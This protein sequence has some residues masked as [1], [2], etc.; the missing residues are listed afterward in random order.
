MP[1]SRT[2]KDE[3]I[4]VT[5][6][7]AKGILNGLEDLC[8]ESDLLSEG[9]LQ[10]LSY[11]TQRSLKRQE[12]YRVILVANG[13][14]DLKKKLLQTIKLIRMS[15]E[16]GFSFEPIGIFYGVGVS[17]DRVAFLFPGQGSQ[18]VDMGRDLASIYGKAFSAWERASSLVFDGQRIIDKVFAAEG[19]KDEELAEMERVLAGSDWTHPCIG[20]VSGS[21]LNLLEAMGLV[22]DAVTGHS[23]GD[24]TA[25]Y[26]AGAISFIEMLQIARKRGALAAFE[27]STRG[28]GVLIVYADIETAKSIISES[29]VEAWI[30]NHNTPTQ[31]VLSARV[32]D[33]ERLE[34]AFDRKGISVKII[35]ISA[36]PHCPIMDEIS[37]LLRDYLED[38]SFQ[39]LRYPLYCTLFGR[40]VPNDPEVMKKVITT[41]MVKTVKFVDQITNMYRD[42]IRTFVEVGPDAVRT[43]FV[44]Q[45]LADKPHA[46]IPLDNRKE[47]GHRV[48]LSGVAELLRTGRSLNLDV[49][50]EDYDAPVRPRSVTPKSSEVG[51]V[52]VTRKEAED[53]SRTWTLEVAKAESILVSRSRVDE[54]AGEF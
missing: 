8:S 20:T 43:K 12:P 41:Q 54:T 9:F 27:P 51:G 48:F 6:E 21:M 31:I 30:A 18:Y 42:G 26:A 44:G 35:P 28:G 11:Q 1:R 17:R 50:W 22:P 37:R 19:A 4:L 5:G 47:D 34:E 52:G 16:R 40:V 14:Q 24:I 32:V 13:E 45:I 7:S 33:F 3:I 29:H 36:A 46:A 39:R 49:L 38:F 23:W 53:I 10:W 25:Y 2:Q 15:P